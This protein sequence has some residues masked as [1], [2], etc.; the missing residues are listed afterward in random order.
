MLTQLILSGIHSGL[1]KYEAKRI[2]IVNLISFLCAVLV[3][4]Y[5]VLFFALSGE[6]RILYPAFLFSPLFSSVIWL[7]SQRYYL[8]AK[9]GLQA[10]FAGI[11]L[12]YGVIFGSLA[13]V[14]LF[15]VFAICVVLLSFKVE[16]L[17]MTLFCA[18][19]PIACV[20]LLELNYELKVINALPFTHEIQH[21][22][23]WLIM[24]VVFSL[25]ILAIAFHCKSNDDLQRQVEWQN[26]WLA[27]YNAELEAQVK[28][29]TA[30]LE[31]ANF[32]KSRYLSETS[33]ETRNYI[34]A[35]IGL[36]D[37]L[38][39]ET[40]DSD[41]PAGSR[42]I[43]EDIFCNS[44]DLRGMLTNVLEVSK[45]E[46]GLGDELRPEPVVL[47]RWLQPVANTY[48]NIAKMGGVQMLVE[49][50]GVL[51]DCVMIDQ[52]KLTRILNNLLSNAI[53]VTPRD[54]VVILGIEAQQDSVIITV[55]DSGPGIAPDKL[56]MLFRPFTQ[57]GMSSDHK[58]SGL[59]LVITRRYVEQLGGVITVE[60]T[61]GMG[62]AFRVRLPLSACEEV[63]RGDELHYPSLH[64]KKVLVIEDEQMNSMI[65]ERF[66][67][68]LGV[69]VATSV[70][71]AEGIAVAQVLKPDL[72]ILDISMPV[73]DGKE[74]TRILRSMPQF[75]GVP[76]I[77]LSSNAFKEEH[78][79]MLGLGA[80]EYI[81]KPV[82]RRQLV[83]SVVRHVNK[84]QLVLLT[85]KEA[86][87]C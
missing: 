61:E 77:A 68:P 81:V 37:I 29:R 59:G 73:M 2:R 39:Q 56:Q 50:S 62:S 75:A 71:G 84:S 33:H 21:V 5:G 76:I 9:V 58:G 17:K 22:F 67:L 35:I 72:I 18:M 66:L 54:R 24:S 20:V 63:Q 60:S 15:A 8:Q 74:T 10:V 31:K 55:K 85:D 14:Q 30:A 43:I 45:I 44:H 12:Y 65:L 64:G 7:N 51:P 23:R 52:S 27:R 83:E 19:L 38:L 80:N 11:I 69:E 53:K 87:A 16:Q 82:L 1:D 86:V 40:Q 47:E 42:Q 6:T 28:E 57:L 41:M 79:M 3:V 70:N 34:N 49:T 32:E 36:S 4:V 26:S 25:C 46:A 48:T 78:E 13:E